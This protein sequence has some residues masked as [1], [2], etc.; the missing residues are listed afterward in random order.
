MPNFV[1]KNDDELFDDGRT[2]NT[3][4]TRKNRKLHAIVRFLFCWTLWICNYMDATANR[5]SQYSIP[6]TYWKSSFIGTI[7]RKSIRTIKYFLI[8]FVFSPFFLDS[9]PDLKRITQILLTLWIAFQSSFFIRTTNHLFV[10][11]NHK[12]TISRYD[13]WY[14]FRRRRFSFEQHLW[15][16]IFYVQIHIPERYFFPRH[17]NKLNCWFICIIFTLITIIILRFRLLL[18][19]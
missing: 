17:D 15:I 10:H 19:S 7:S 13:G 6:F 2:N 5:K 1:N 8:F 16:F 18:P 14:W 4:R 9:R 12:Y 3:K 11:E